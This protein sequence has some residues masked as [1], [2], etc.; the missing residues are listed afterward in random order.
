MI[1]G[2]PKEIKDNEYRVS[3]VP[4]GV[5]V[6]VNAGHQVLVE[7]SAGVGSG[8]PDE[9]Y[10]RAGASLVGLAE[11]VFARA[12]M[13]V[14]VKEPLPQ[15]WPLLRKRQILFTYLHL[16]PLPDLTKELLAREVTGIAYETMEDGDG[17]LPLLTQ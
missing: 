11:E 14:K 9:D 15:E 16:A 17:S 2:V 1:V 10:A 8:L 12:D 5:K 7:K 6:L 3:M 4:A 13:I